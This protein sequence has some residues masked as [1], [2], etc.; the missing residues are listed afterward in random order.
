M[1]KGANG[2]MTKLKYLSR[3][4]LYIIN[5][6][7][8]GEK[9]L[10]LSF[11]LTTIILACCWPS[12]SFGQENNTTNIPSTVTNIFSNISTGD[13]LLLIL[14]F[15]TFI[16]FLAGTFI[17]RKYK[18]IE[19][20]QHEYSKF[21]NPS[22]VKLEYDKNSRGLKY[23]TQSDSDW[24]DFFYEV[25]RQKKYREYKLQELYEKAEGEVNNYH[26]AVNSTSKDINEKFNA[27]FKKRDDLDYIIWNGEG[28]KPLNDYI[29]NMH[30][31]LNIENMIN[32]VATHIYEPGTNG[33]YR[34]ACTHRLA[35]STSK[36]K[37][38]KLK[39]LFENLANDDGVKGLFENRDKAKSDM[40]KALQDYNDKLSEVIR[41]LKMYPR[42]LF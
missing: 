21:L 25:K 27:E 28:D 9:R 29:D 5:T 39:D 14:I 36:S 6:L 17:Q 11:V 10:V 12:I 40:D 32:G 41:D 37:I 24:N 30:I 26:R 8:K 31:P 15:I 18:V 22:E 23:S 38:E 33:R 20:I 13:F 2:K 35:K 16:I 34:L 19:R 7:D 42:R 4:N 1:V 3:E